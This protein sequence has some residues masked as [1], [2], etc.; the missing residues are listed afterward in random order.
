MKLNYHLGHVL[1]KIQRLRS[2]EQCWVVVCALS[3][4][5]VEGT[6]GIVLNHLVRC[7]AIGVFHRWLVGD[8]PLIVTIQ[9]M[10]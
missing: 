3:L 5:V 9:I 8:L 1:G 6:S 10:G 4:S 7:E 2:T